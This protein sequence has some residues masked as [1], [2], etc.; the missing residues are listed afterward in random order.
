MDDLVNL[1]SQVRSEGDTSPTMGNAN[2]V[3]VRL[4]V[5][6]LAMLFTQFAAA[7]DIVWIQKGLKAESFGA[8][9]TATERADVMRRFIAEHGAEVSPVDILIWKDEFDFGKDFPVEIPLCTHVSDR[10][11]VHHQI[12]IDKTEHKPLGTCG[13]IVNGSARFFGFR[14]KAK[15]W[16]KNEDAGIFCSN[17]ACDLVIEFIDCEFDCGEDC[18]WGFWYNWTPGRK[19]VIVRGLPRG[20]DLDPAD[21]PALLT[22]RCPPRKSKF[23]RF[24]VAQASSAADQGQSVWIENFWAEGRADGST[25]Y[26]DSSRLDYDVNKDGK[27]DAGSGTALSLLLLRNGT[28]TLRNVHVEAYGQ[29]V[30]YDKG[31]KFGVGRIAAWVTDQLLTAAQPTTVTI[32]SDCTSKIEPGPFAAV[33]NDVDLRY[34]K[35]VF[36]GGGSGEAGAVRQFQK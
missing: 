1:Y 5:L 10:A 23:C 29:T 19:S 8:A 27:I 2:L 9:T 4:A 33:V 16:D 32:Y 7:E 11:Y 30:A 26:G 12:Q 35:P 22:D 18:D 14:F 21:W 31:N 24:L 6:M 28:A 25:T 20:D 3:A 13:F 17:K 15:C 34:G 36:L